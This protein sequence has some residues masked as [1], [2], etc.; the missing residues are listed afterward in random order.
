MRPEIAQLISP[1]IYQKLENHPSV[2]EYE[3]IKVSSAFV[4]GYLAK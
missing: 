2:L 1:H 3:N 4:P